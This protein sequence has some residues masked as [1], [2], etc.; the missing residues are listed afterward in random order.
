MSPSK[1]QLIDAMNPISVA[2]YIVP[3][4][5]AMIRVG[6]MDEKRRLFEAFIEA[7]GIE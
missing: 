1:Q 7:G 6:T 4:V 3:L 2:F 5:N